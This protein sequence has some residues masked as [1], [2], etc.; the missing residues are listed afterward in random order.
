MTC[1]NLSYWGTIKVH[2]F[3]HRKP[4]RTLGPPLTYT[5]SETFSRKWSHLKKQARVWGGGGGVKE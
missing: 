3:K 2:I 5:T 1:C 4:M